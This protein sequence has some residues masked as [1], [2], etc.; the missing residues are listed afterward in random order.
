[1]DHHD[2]LIEILYVGP[3]TFAQQG[4]ESAPAK[5]GHSVSKQFKANQCSGSMPR[6]KRYAPTFSISVWKQM[7]KNPSM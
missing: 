3:S 1:M 6:L 7:N 2:P 5:L 4:L